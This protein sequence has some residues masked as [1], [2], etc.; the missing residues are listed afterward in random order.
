MPSSATVTATWQSSHTAV[1]RMTDDSG[2]CLAALDKRLDR[3]WTMRGRSAMT[4]G[5]SS[6]R[7]RVEV[8]PA[9]AA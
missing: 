2:E 7:S 1:T 9:A 8:V 5:K 4:K 6:A 3:T